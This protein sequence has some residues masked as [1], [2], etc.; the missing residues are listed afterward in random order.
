MSLESLP[1]FYVTCKLQASRVVN[2]HSSRSVS[3]TITIELLYG[4]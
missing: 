3:H 4:T 2:V 1:K